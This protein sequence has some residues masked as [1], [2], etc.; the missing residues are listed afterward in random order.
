[1]RG[2]LL[3][4]FVVILM[5]GGMYEYRAH[6]AAAATS[7]RGSAADAAITE[8]SVTAFIYHM[9]G[10]VGNPSALTKVRCVPASAWPS[11]FQHDP[12]QPYDCRAIYTT[13]IQRWCILF[14]PEYDQ[15]VTYFQGQRMCEGP[16]DPTI[17]P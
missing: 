2:T 6:H 5:G 4:L 16:P 15:L 17:K 13:G 9:Q 8:A 10:E 12:G 11:I 1:M 7:H 14:N 3:V